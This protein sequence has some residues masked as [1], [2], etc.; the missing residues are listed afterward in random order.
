MESTLK[1]DKKPL[2]GSNWLGIYLEE[3]M[4]NPFEWRKSLI[5]EVVRTGR[6]SDGM[7]QF[8]LQDLPFSAT[9]ER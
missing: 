2:L 7:V 8:E 3:T 9:G 5:K 1:H 4:N 6:R